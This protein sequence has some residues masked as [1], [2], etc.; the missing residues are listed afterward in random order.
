MTVILPL[1]VKPLQI[2]INKSGHSFL[3]H[4]DAFR[5]ALKGINLVKKEKQ[6]E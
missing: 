3:L 6:I 4:E 5:L 1:I 2:L